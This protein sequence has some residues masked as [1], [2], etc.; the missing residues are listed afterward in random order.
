MVASEE[1][2]PLWITPLLNY[3][4]KDPESGHYEVLQR[5]V[6]SSPKEPDQEE[7]EI[8]TALE[9]FIGPDG[10]A[11][12]QS[13]VVRSGQSGPSQVVHASYIHQDDCASISSDSVLCWTAFPE[14]PDHKMLCVLASPIHKGKRRIWVVKAIPSL[15]L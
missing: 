14:R 2:T 7:A 6:S 5:L 11:L 3:Q 9:T 1:A 8:K 15:S 13:V 4:R 10:I 12:W